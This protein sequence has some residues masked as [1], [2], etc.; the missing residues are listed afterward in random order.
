MKLGF[1][2][3]FSFAKI[4]EKRNNKI[5]NKKNNS[6]QIYERQKSFVFMFYAGKTKKKK[7]TTN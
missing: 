6:V 5:Q 2:L 7:I 3:T 4:T 1:T